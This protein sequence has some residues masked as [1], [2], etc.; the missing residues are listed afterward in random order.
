MPPRSETVTPS[1][2]ERRLPSGRHDIIFRV[3]FGSDAA[4]ARKLRVSRMTIWRWRHD[5]APLPRWVVE[6]LPNLIQ[7]K[8]AGSN[9]RSACRRTADA[10]ASVFPDSVC[11]TSPNGSQ[12]AI[13]A[14]WSPLH[15]RRVLIWPDADEPGSTYAAEVA[16]ILHPLH[17][18]VSII[19]AS[20]LA[21]VDPNGDQR[22]PAKGWD[23][24]DAIAEWENL[25]ALRKAA[26]GLAKPFEPGAPGAFYANR[27][28]Q[29]FWT[30]SLLP[31][32]GIKP[33][34]ISWLWRD[35][36]ARGKMHIIAG[37]P[38]TG[39]TTLAMKMAA[40]V[41]ARS[42]WPDGTEATKGSVIIWSGEDDPADTLVPW[43]EASGADL[44]RIFF[45]GEMSCR[46]ERRDFDPAKDI[47][48]LQAAIETAGGSSLI[49]VD[50]IVSATAADS[51]KNSETR[52]GLQPLVDMAAKLD[53]ALLGITHFTKGS[54]GR[55]PI[56]RV[57]GSVAFGALARVVMVAAKQQDGDHGKSA[58]RMLMRAKSNFGPDE[59][60]FAYSLELVPMFE[61]PD[62]V[63][64]VVSWGESI[65]GNAREIL[66]EAEEV[67]D[68]EAAGAL[69]E[70]TD[71]L[72]DLLI[73]GPKSAK[74][75]RAAARDAG[76]SP[77]T[78]DRAKSKLGIA[79]VKDR[80]TGG[81]KW[82]RPEKRQG[83]RG[84]ASFED[85]QVRQES[86]LRGESEA[87]SDDWE[88]DL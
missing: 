76:H 38:G 36:L 40:T 25:S 79:S 56:D 10:A 32:S 61:R 55:S 71:F 88:G 41:S 51:H 72:L 49:I 42:R 3:A 29:P 31:A 86:L 30:M 58:P 24:A 78:I 27:E 85:L 83:R 5:C 6:A 17:C 70:A 45:A 50:P 19:D 52:R 67:P 21:S 65:D 44:N 18:Q 12:S 87:V 4:A 33:E 74:E 75:V 34:P 46:K 8:A 66:A 37:Q 60:G 26:Y 68:K 77:R 59:G 81:W 11:V 43:L 13:K 7:N 39:K 62:I 14:D 35:W 82:S 69:Q 16:A 63:A 53:A 57:T 48:A 54:E 15:G 20:A 84:L 2:S 80:L 1:R 9:T 47:T 28:A 64:S 22:G 73:D 23:A